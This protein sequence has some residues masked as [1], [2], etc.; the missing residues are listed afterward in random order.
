VEK[1]S[2]EY[3][4]NPR[5][6]GTG[7]YIG[8]ELEV[9]AP[10]LEAERTGL[11][12]AGQPTWCYAKRD[13]SLGAYGVEFVTHPIA[14]NYWMSGEAISE[15]RDYHVLTPGQVLTGRYKGVTYTA[16]VGADAKRVIWNGTTY[17]SISACGKAIRGGKSTNGYDFFGLTRNASNNPNPVGSFFALAANLARLHYRSHDGGRCGFHVHVSRTA[18]SANGRLDNPMFFR[19]K[20]LVN[21]TLFRRLSQ[22]EVFAYCAQEPVDQYTFYHQN[23]S[24]YVAC[25]TTSNTVEVR[26]F[27]GNLRESRLRKNIEAVIAAIEWAKESESYDRPTDEQFIAWVADHRERFPNLHAYI[28]TINRPAPEVC[29]PMPQDVA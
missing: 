25:N 4:P 14:V 1:R 9:E 6:F 17:T 7:V 21:G 2:H 12:E 15:Y 28:E 13:G 23:Y 16:T 24:R 27:R 5:F 18:F 3:K 22:R 8:L 19:F 20:C 11:R 10:S 29:G 26:L